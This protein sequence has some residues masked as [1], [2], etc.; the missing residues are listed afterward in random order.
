MGYGD[1]YCHRFNADDTGLCLDDAGDEW[2]K[3]TTACLQN[4]LVAIVEQDV[5]ELNCRY[6]KTTAFDSHPLCYTGGGEIEPVGPSI[7]FLPL[8]DWKCVLATVDP[9]D[10]LTPLGIQQELR[11]AA[12]CLE[13]LVAAGICSTE[14]PQNEDERCAYWSELM[15]L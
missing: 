2:V 11:I 9:K 8:S 4:Q 3:S 1:K 5:K 14:R 15:K 6:I 7:C 12:I 10:L 13:Q